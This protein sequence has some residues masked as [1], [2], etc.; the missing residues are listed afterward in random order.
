MELLRL[1]TPKLISY[2]KI[3]F[4]LMHTLDRYEQS[5]ACDRSYVTG[6]IIILN[7][8]AAFNLHP[9]KRQFAVAI[10]SV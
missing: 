8:K 5:L 9:S 3:K 4:V 1:N 7:N 10:F 6:T 2:Y